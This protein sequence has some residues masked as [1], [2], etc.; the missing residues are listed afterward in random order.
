[1]NY[2]VVLIV[3]N[4]PEVTRRVLYEIA[5]A[6]PTE[7]YIIADGP[8]SHAP[9]DQSTCEKTRAIVSNSNIDWDCQ[10][11]RN[12][13]D[14][15]LGCRQRVVS[16]LDWVF[17]QTEAAIIL[18]D[19]CLPEPSFFSF[20]SE[21]LKH[22][23]DDKRVMAISGDNFQKGR[24]HGKESYYF[25][26]YVHCWGWATWQRAWRYNDASMSQW[27]QVKESGRLKDV[28]GDQNGLRYWYQKFEQVY[29][30]KVDT[31]DYGWLLSCWLQSGLCIL[32]NCNLVSNVGFGAE[33]TH[34]FS[35]DDPLANLKTEPILFPL[36]HPQWIVRD[37]AADRFTQQ[38]IYGFSVRFRRKLNTFL[39][40]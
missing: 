15:N 18:E 11:Y 4:R 22:Y 16:G 17:S 14:V 34:H 8:R 35:Q 32:P 36:S 7:L 3:F 23:R 12:Y 20:C 37:V 40:W 19:D 21:L 28:L 27:P 38:H 29:S 30:G 10:V 39:R 2:P 13:S 5:A 25:S 33:G 26:R 6:K 9:E 1:M 24:Q 31:W